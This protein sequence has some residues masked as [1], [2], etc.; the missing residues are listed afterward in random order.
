MPQLDFMIVA[1]Y[2][3]AEGGVLH[4][5]AAGIDTIYT[6]AVPAIRQVGIGIRLTM[7]PAEARHQHLIEVIFQNEDGV[8]VAQINGGFAPQGDV[9]NLPAGVRPSIAIP[10]NMNLPLPAYGRY[11][12]ELLV[13]ANSMKSVEMTVSPPPAGVPEEPGVPGHA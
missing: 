12:L 13:D 6:P 8:R 3:R 5:I 11:S 10:F 7:T 4:M 9:P 1:D 2:V